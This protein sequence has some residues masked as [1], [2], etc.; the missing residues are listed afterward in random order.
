M[1]NTLKT[2]MNSFIHLLFPPCCV[3]C[4]SPLIEEEEMLCTHCNMDMPRTNYHLCV[5]NPVER[6]FWGKFPLERAT[7]YF[8]YRKGSDFRRILHELKYGGKKQLGTTMGR[9]IAAEL[10]QSSFFKDMDLIVPVPLHPLKQKARG[11]NQTEYIARGISAI[12]K[13]PMET[14]SLIRNKHTETQTKKSFYERSENVSGVF[15]ILH[16]EIFEGKHILIVDD[17]LTTGATT[18]ACADA[19]SGIRNVRISILTLAVAE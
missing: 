9:F 15:S 4:G 3:A 16:P 14:T 13:I 1:E 6:M 11:Y 18:T 10:S 5:D 12:S 7:S 2:W 17:V 19:F 8:F